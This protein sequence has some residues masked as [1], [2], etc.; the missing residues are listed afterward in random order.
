MSWASPAN[1]TG[2]PSGPVASATMSAGSDNAGAVVST[3]VT[4]NDAVAMFPTASVAVTVTVVVPSGNVL[5]AGGV[6]ATGTGPL[7]RSLA[8]T[9]RATRAPDAPVASTVT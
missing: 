9:D 3:T 5:S 2:A 6:T 4:S 7:T 8:L 1:V